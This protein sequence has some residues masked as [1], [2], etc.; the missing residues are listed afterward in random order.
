M[1]DALATV[2]PDWEGMLRN[3]RR[4]GTPDRVYYFEHG[5]AD[6]ILDALDARFEISRALDPT[7]SD[8]AYRRVLA[9]HRFL[10]LEL[11]R[12]FPLGARMS[13]LRK[14]GEWA[15]EHQGPIG[16]WEYFERYDWPRPEDADLSVLEYYEANLP[17]DMRAFQVLDVWEVVRELFGF[18]TFC[19]KLY[20]EPGL[21]EAVVERVGGFAETMTRALCDFE[22]L[23]VVYLADDLGYK[24]STMISPDDIRRLI[25]PWH[26]RIADLSHEHGKIVFFHCCGQMYELIDDYIDDVKID[27]KHSFEENVLPV[28]EV[29]RRYGERLSLLGGID[30]DLLARGNEE[31]IRAKTREVLDVCMPGGGYFLG[32][33]NWVSEYIPVGNY[34]FM[35]DEA[36]RYA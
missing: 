17:E 21:V 14:H 28:T 3:L 6:N 32:S 18:E 29:K 25:L 26:K 16:S 24:T 36:R 23:G 22:C 9:I 2:R 10:G 33:G 30:V 19:Y 4:E 11:F 7:D 8:Y 34:L 27:A 1:I 12:V 20:E 35:L 15:D 13:V 5:I 31:S